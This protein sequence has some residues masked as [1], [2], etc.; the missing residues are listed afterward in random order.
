M[1][2]IWTD[3]KLGF[4]R[5][6]A[7]ILTTRQIA[8]K[9]DTNIT[10]VR[11]MAYRL[12][13]HLRVP[14]YNEKDLEQVQALYDSPENLSLK[15]IAK[16]TGLTLSTLHYILYVKSNHALYNK[17]EYVLFDTED[18]VQ[19]R[20]PKDVLDL[21]SSSLDNI[22]SENDVREIYL[23]DGTCFSARN[24]KQEVVISRTRA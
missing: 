11:N 19:Y 18:A 1:A 12:N 7:G 16:K 21:E 9:L 5:K 10:V 14:K 6:S 3:K 17:T 24:I 22:A 13:L 2:F 15:E 23:M 8:E 20:V 4:L